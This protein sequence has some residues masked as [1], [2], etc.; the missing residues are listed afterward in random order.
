MQINSSADL[1]FENLHQPGLAFRYGMEGAIEIRDAKEKASQRRALRRLE[2]KNMLKIERISNKYQIL[3]TDR[4]KLEVLRLEILSAEEL[5]DGNDCIVVFDIPESNRKMRKQMRELLKDAGF[6]CMQ[7][8]VWISPFDAG[9]ALSRF[10][11]HN[12]EQEWVRIY[13]GNRH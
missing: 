10:F 1:L 8:S 11:Y 6:F 4:G 9:N 5:P 2:K 12:G 13:T 3:L 7:K